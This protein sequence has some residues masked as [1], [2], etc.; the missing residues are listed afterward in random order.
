MEKT[1]DQDKIRALHNC[2]SDIYDLIDRLNEI[3]IDIGLGYQNLRDATINI[4][5][6]ISRCI[7]EIINNENK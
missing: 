3:G 5:K 7:D 6:A 1:Q 2:N 4:Q